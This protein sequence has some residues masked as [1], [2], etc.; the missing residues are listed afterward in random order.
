MF[1]GLTSG[2]SYADGFSAGSKF[3]MTEVRGSVTVNCYDRD[4]YG[5]GPS[6]ARFNCEEYILDPVETDYFVTDEAVD[7]DKV[8][9][10]NVIDGKTI[11]KTKNYSA[12][13]KR[14]TSR[15]NLWLASLLQTPLLTVGKNTLTYE[16][17]NGRSVVK[18]GTFEVDVEVAS[19]RTCRHGY[20]T[21]Y[22]S[23]DCRF[24]S[25]ACRI[26]FSRENYCQ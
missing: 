15:F 17:K 13:E 4:D 23:N 9:I 14:S 10:T 22:D 2:L 6:Y 16:L 24:S 18:S 5:G 7:A 11:D 25:S 26:Y 12:K 1:A 21:S 19:P 8:T 3:Q 20:I